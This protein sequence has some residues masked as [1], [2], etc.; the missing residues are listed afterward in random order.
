MP[1]TADG[2]IVS[3]S[4][5]TIFGKIPNGF[6]ESLNA[7]CEPSLQLVQKTVA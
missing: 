1:I 5:P 4:D 2:A 3:F 6:L 7:A